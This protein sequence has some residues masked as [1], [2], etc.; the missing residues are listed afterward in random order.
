MASADPKRAAIILLSDKFRV[1]NKN[2]TNTLYRSTLAN[3]G[4]EI[5]RSAAYMYCFQQH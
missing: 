3:Y 4:T 2:H 1:K 5:G